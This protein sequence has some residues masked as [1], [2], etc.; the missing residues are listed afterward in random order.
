MQFVTHLLAKTSKYYGGAHSD[1]RSALGV[2][3]SFIDALMKVKRSQQKFIAEISRCQ[4]KIRYKSDK[5]VFKI[6]FTVLFRSLLEV[7]HTRGFNKYGRVNGN[8]VF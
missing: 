5:P 3:F 2:L 8:I 7:S 6:S 4:E 1:H